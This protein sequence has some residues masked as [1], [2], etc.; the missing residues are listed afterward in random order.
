MQ[1]ATAVDM[2]AHEIPKEVF[3]PDT[4]RE[5]AHINDVEVVCYICFTHDG[6]ANR[7]CLA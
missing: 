7:E 5:Q 3:A 4:F 2:T 6:S 1:A